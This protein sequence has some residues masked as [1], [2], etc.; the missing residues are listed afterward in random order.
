[1]GG[2]TR[3]DDKGVG[4]SGGESRVLDREEGGGGGML[5]GRPTVEKKVGATNCGEEGRHATAP[6]TGHMVTR[7]LKKALK[8]KP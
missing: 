2:A 4:A 6:G 5:D 8:L 3:R 7:P 1:V